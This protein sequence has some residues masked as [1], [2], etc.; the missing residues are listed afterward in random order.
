MGGIF[1]LEDLQG[2]DTGPTLTG[3]AS[4]CGTGLVEKS[5]V[6]LHHDSLMAQLK[7]Q[8]PYR[9]SISRTAAPLMYYW[10]QQSQRCLGCPGNAHFL[11]QDKN[12]AKMTRGKR[13]E[14]QRLVFLMR[15]RFLIFACAYRALLEK[16]FLLGD[17]LIVIKHRAQYAQQQRIN[18]P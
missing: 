16:N 15:R 1:A 12:H 5:P 2:T 10:P 4:V 17:G 14:R 18:N 3:L 11:Q 6:M 8:T 9:K 7:S 13:N